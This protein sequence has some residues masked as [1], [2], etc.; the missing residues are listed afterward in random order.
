M[1]EINL[2]GERKVLVENVGE[3]CFLRTLSNVWQY[4]YSIKGLKHVKNSEQI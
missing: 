3:V 4:C 1:S 2:S